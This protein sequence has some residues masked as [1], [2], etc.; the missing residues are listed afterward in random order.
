[1]G[2]SAI[3]GLSEKLLQELYV[4]S[5][6]DPGKYMQAMTPACALALAANFGSVERWRDEFIAK[7]KSM[8]GG[9]G[10]LL[11][12]FQP[13]QGTLLNQC[14]ADHTQ[15]LAGGVPVLALA[16]ALVPGR[17]EHAD[18]PDD[19]AAAGTDGDA[20]MARIDWADVYERYRLAVNSAS[21]APGAALGASADQAAGAVLIDVRRAGVL[22]A[23]STVILGANWRDP[24]SV[25]N[26]AAEMPADR[27]VIVY[28][29]HGHEVSR[30]TALRLRAA[31]LKARYL[32]GGIEA[33][34]AAGRPLA[35]KA[36]AWVP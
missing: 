6:G 29:V 3:S 35:E 27:E 28:C 23:T 33:W 30:A 36:K 26:W 13:R 14:V 32:R 9:S 31:G 10:W 34:Q 8:G 7:G 4:G 17:H 5:L 11:L 22:D 19:G 12:V 15:V 2:A 1:M 25:G 20:L 21:E 18:H 24:A 16:L